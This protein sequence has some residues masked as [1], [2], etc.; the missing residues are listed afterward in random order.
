MLSANREHGIC[1][2][3]N[4][5]LVRAQRNNAVNPLPGT[6]VSQVDRIGGDRGRVHRLT[7]DHGDHSIHRHPGRAVRWTDVGHK[8]LDRIDQVTGGVTGGEFRR[9]RVAGDIAHTAYMDGV[10][11]V[12]LQQVIR[13]KQ[14]FRITGNQLQCAS[15]GTTLRIQQFQAGGCHRLRQ[16]GFVEYYTDR[17]VLGHVHRASRRRH[18]RHLRGCSVRIQR[19]GLGIHLILVADTV[20]VGIRFERVCTDR[21]FLPIQQAIPISVRVGGIRSVGCRL[22]VIAQ[23]VMVGVG[24]DE[25]VTCAALC[26]VPAQVRGDRPQLEFRN[27]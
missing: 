24:L 13:G 25:Y 3:C 12:V 1:H 6:R 2:E 23:P 27:A 22:L 19:V 18:G 10:Q 14:Q 15:H 17:L 4:R 8:R 5:G 9:N 21:H 20:T 7:H 11:G 16:Q 26:G